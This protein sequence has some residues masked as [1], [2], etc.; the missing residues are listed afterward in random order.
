MNFWFFQI[1]LLILN[2]KSLTNIS[3]RNSL[4]DEA[5]KAFKQKDYYKA[6]LRYESLKTSSFTFEPEARLNLAHSYFFI[7]DTTKALQEYRKL[8]KI[9]DK[10]IKST[11]LIQIGILNCQLGDS[12]MAMQLFKEAIQKDP[13]NAVAQYNY[14]LLRKKLPPPPSQ[15]NNNTQNQQEEKQEAAPEQTEKKE[16]ELNSLKPQR[17]SKDKALQILES[18]KANELQYLQQKKNTKQS[19]KYNDY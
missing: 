9:S 7:K 13:S 1:L 5:E 3:A 18:M 16:D 4:K 14:E 2:L 19:K 17:M 8:I 15:N 6:I 12:S 10:Q 11:T